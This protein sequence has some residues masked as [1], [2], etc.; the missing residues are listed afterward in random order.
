MSFFSTD[1][2]D[3]ILNNVM[4][5]LF[6]QFSKTGYVVSYDKNAFYG[7]CKSNNDLQSFIDQ[8]YNDQ[9]TIVKDNEGECIQYIVTIDNQSATIK[10]NQTKDKLW[11]GKFFVSVNLQLKKGG[12]IKP[13]FTFLK[14]RSCNRRSIDNVV[15]SYQA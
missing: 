15:Q 12:F 11:F 2:D 5:Y 1:Q 10:I 3:V 9:N 4:Q 7:Y 6:D 8:L 14:I 13:P